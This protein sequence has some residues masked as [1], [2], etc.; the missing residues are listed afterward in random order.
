M[1]WSWEYVGALPVSNGVL[2]MRSEPTGEPY[3]S[4]V[5]LNSFTELRKMSLP[6]RPQEKN[7]TTNSQS[8]LGLLLLFGFEVARV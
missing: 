7:V 3:S 8:I 4:I 2:V 1:I 6:R 5:P